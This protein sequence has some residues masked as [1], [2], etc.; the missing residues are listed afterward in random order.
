M[1]SSLDYNQVEIHHRLYI[2][3]YGLDSNN[4]K[5]QGIIRVVNGVNSGGI[6]LID[7]IGSQAHLE[8]RSLVKSSSHSCLLTLR[9]Q[10]A[11]Q[12]DGIQTALTALA[13]TGLE[14]AITELA[15]AGASS[16]D[17]T[18]VVKACLAISKCVGITTVALTDSVSILYLCSG[19]VEKLIHN[20]R[21]LIML[22][23]STTSTCLNPL[24]QL[25]SMF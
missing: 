24:T 18:T 1:G 14:V 20:V 3:D 7:G 16:S 19:T 12:A 22:P 15:I 25:F 10:Q 4:A 13:S 8:V 23:Y 11:G 6:R 21:M 2:N 5:V 9:C 17:Y